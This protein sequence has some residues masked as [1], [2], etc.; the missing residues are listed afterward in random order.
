MVTKISYNYEEKMKNE[1]TFI[2]GMPRAICVMGRWS[3]GRGAWGMLFPM[4]DEDCDV[5]VGS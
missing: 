3:M 4:S 1:I 5:F 2:S